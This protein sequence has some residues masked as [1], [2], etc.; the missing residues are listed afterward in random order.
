MDRRR[1]L[2]AL[3]A[4]N[5]DEFPKRTVASNRIRSRSETA[6]TESKERNGIRKGSK[7][8]VSPPLASR[9]SISLS[10]SL[11]LCFSLSLSL[12]Q[13][14]AYA[15]T[16]CNH[17]TIIMAMVYNNLGCWTMNTIP[18]ANSTWEWKEIKEWMNANAM[19][20]FHLLIF[21]DRTIIIIIK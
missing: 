21:N 15:C 11:S 7:N 1:S 5:D 18:T 9:L 2:W 20:W 19:Q 8:I 13:R 10:H 6:Y 14:I 17:C 12:T 16:K 3:A 4:T